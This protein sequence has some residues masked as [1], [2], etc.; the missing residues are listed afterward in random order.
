MPSCFTA[1]SFPIEVSSIIVLFHFLLP[2]LAPGKSAMMSEQYEV[3]AKESTVLTRKSIYLSNQ[4][5][6]F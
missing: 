6:V 4:S 1:A 3:L 2:C 5:V